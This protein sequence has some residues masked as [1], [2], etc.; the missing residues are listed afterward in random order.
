MRNGHSRMDVQIKVEPKEVFFY[1]DKLKRKIKIVNLNEYS[2]KFE[3]LTVLN[4]LN[5]SPLQANETQAIIEPDQSFTV[6]L[7]YKDSKEKDCD[8]IIIL[9]IYK[10]IDGDLIDPEPIRE[11]IHVPFHFRKIHLVGSESEKNADVKPESIRNS[12]QPI[13]RDTDKVKKTKDEP[14]DLLE[15]LSRDLSIDEKQASSDSEPAQQ[16]TKIKKKNRFKKPSKFQM[17]RSRKTKEKP[18]DKLGKFGEALQDQAEQL[19]EKLKGTE[20]A[21][22]KEI[23][24]ESDKETEKSEY[25]SDSH[26]DENLDT[27]M[28]SLVSKFKKNVRELGQGVKNALDRTLDKTKQHPDLKK[29]GNQISGQIGKQFRRESNDSTSYQDDLSLYEHNQINS[30]RYEENNVRKLAKLIFLFTFFNFCYTVF[31]AFFNPLNQLWLDLIDNY[32]LAAT[33][34]R[35]T[36]WPEL[37]QLFKNI[38]C[39]KRDKT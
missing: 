29:I 7:E 3:L 20:T 16:P 30:L 14:K 35:C 19:A 39:F 6:S 5:Q 28:D 33:S 36:T 10:V 17:F 37:G 15:D 12:D 38:T 22:E 27:K 11:P 1:L 23:K 21:G 25:N 8:S 26:S 13:A 32:S 2:V 31:L 18:S 24:K 4:D 34:S 9:A